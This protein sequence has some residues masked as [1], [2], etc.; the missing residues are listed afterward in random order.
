MSTTEFYMETTGSVTPISNELAEQ[1][2]IGR[3]LVDPEA[4]GKVMPT[5]LPEAPG[6]V[7]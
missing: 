2:I 6:C 1:L 4:I 5:L 3:I 7:E